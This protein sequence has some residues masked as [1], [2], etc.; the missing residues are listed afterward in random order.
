M[1]L[2]L[3]VAIGR[4]KWPKE[5]PGSKFFNFHVV[6]GQTICKILGCSEL[7]PL[8]HENC[9]SATGDLIKKVL[10]FHLH[11]R[12]HFGH[13]WGWGCLLNGFSQQILKR[14]TSGQR[15]VLPAPYGRHAIEESHG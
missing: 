10:A 1:R 15:C 13:G 8:R 7:A 4:S 2:I 14:F 5:A 9:G 12:D 6:F 3:T 11:Q